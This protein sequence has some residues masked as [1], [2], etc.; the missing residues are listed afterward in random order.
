[1]IFRALMVWLLIMAGARADAWQQA[2]VDYALH[3]P[4]DHG[5]HATQRIEWWYFTGNVAAADGQAFGYQ[6]TFFRIGTEFAPANPS[7]WAVRD[8][9]LAH[10]AISDLT[11]GKYHCAQR[12]ARSGP[13]LAGAMADQL[14][15]WNGTWRAEW[16]DGKI[17][18]TAQEN[19]AFS[20]HLTLATDGPLVA[21]GDDGYSRKGQQ[22]GN[23]SIYYSFPRMATTGE[24]QLGEQRWSVTGQSWMDHEFGTSFLELGQ[25][26]WDWFAMQMDDGAELMLFQIRNILPHTP[27]NLSGT[28]IAADGTATKL[29]ADQIQ[30]T[31]TEPWKSPNT[32]AAYPLHWEINLPSQHLILKVTTP[33]AGQE[34][35]GPAAGPSYWE[36]AVVAA[37]TRNGQPMRGKGYLEMT[38]YAVG[39]ASF[40]SLGK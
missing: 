35:H 34:M 5:S 29:S 9:H 32:G 18:L 25:T 30:L 11:A 17:S 26:G 13:G 23:A 38:G 24:M 15:V 20:M 1:M 19:E 12:L 7:V 22:S 10:F 36:G 8:L 3:F 37:G 40:F 6:L 2:P 21:H 28:W 33:L 31:A 27:P 16:Q 14:Q 39:M 4:E